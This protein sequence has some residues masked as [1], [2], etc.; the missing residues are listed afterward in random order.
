MFWGLKDKKKGRKEEIESWNE[1]TFSRSTHQR[2]TIEWI[3]QC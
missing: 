3:M 2:L 1:A